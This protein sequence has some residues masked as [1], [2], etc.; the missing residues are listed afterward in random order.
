[1]A[2]EYDEEKRQASRKARGPDMARAGEVFDGPTIS[3]PDDRRDYG[4]FRTITIGLLDGRMVVLIWTM[5][6]ARRRVISMR[7]AND[8]EQNRF[9]PRLC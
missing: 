6:G 3:Q 8:R 7:K 9:G 4:E 1:M 5:R 2:V